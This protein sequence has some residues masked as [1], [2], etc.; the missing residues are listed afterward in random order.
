MMTRLLKFWTGSTICKT[1]YYAFLATRYWFRYVQGR[2]IH[3]K[4]ILGKNRVGKQLVLR[5]RLPPPHE[6]SA[7]IQ[8]TH[9]SRSTKPY[10]LP[11]SGTV[12]AYELWTSFFW[13]YGF[14]D[15]WWF[16]EMYLICGSVAWSR[17]QYERGLV[18][19]LWRGLGEPPWGCCLWLKLMCLLGYFKIST[20][21]LSETFL[22]I[23]I[24]LRFAI[25]HANNSENVFH[26]HKIFG[27]ED[28]KWN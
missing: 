11:V 28:D 19:S 20:N 18:W 16:F 12:F 17:T 7:S 9:N 6:V 5:T 2:K 13:I 24:S 8:E 14:P 4:W 25:S 27:Y 15:F 3:L 21:C 26:D 22:H 23:D 1:L 10:K